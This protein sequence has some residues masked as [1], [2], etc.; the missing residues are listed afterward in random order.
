L[1]EPVVDPLSLGIEVLEATAPPPAA[2]ARSRTAGAPQ[3][4]HG[5]SGAPGQRR[6]R[7]VACALRGL[8][9]EQR[10]VPVS[11]ALRLRHGD[12]TTLRHVRP[13]GARK[14][15][16]ATEAFS[17]PER[18]SGPR[19]WQPRCACEPF[20]YGYARPS[21]LPHSASPVRGEGDH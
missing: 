21:S 9:L 15:G 8:G 20:A 6:A 12:R 16:Y 3:P 18:E 7:F 13:N 11:R 14:A 17:R 2:D 1:A 5:R 10:D 19:A 4:R